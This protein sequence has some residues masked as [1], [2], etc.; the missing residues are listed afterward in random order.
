MMMIMD[1][2]PS[3]KNP[4]TSFGDESF[5]VED[6]TT[7]TAIHEENLEILRKM[8]EADILKEQQQIMQSVGKFREHFFTCLNCLQVW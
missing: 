4:K 1:C 5:I 7:A 8:K 2:E 6:Q 3:E